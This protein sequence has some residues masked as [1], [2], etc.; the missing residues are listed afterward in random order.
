MITISVRSTFNIKTLI[1]TLS[2]NSRASLA[3]CD[4]IYEFYNQIGG[5]CGS[6]RADYTNLLSALIID[7]DGNVFLEAVCRIDLKISFAQV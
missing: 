4:F 7:G 3:S 5:S 1:T 2:H 6:G